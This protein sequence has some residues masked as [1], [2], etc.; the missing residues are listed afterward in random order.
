MTVDL[1]DYF[2]DLDFD[3]WPNYESRIMKTTTILLELFK[4]YKVTATFFT[5]GYI[6]EQFPELIERIVQEGHEVASH[7]YSHLD[8]RK[9]TKDQFE[10]D[11]VKSI[12]ILE[13]TAGEK[14]HGFRAPFFSINHET[15]WALDI[16]KKYLKYDSSI[17]PVRT[18]LYGISNAPRTIYHPSQK[19]P[20]RN[21]DEE[22]FLELPPAT[23]AI[24]IIGNI[25]I[26]GGFHLRF[27]PYNCIKSGIKKI[28]KNANPAVCYIHPKDLDPKMPRIPQYKWHYYYG[29]KGALRKFENLLRD[30]KFESV[31][32]A[33]PI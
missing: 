12:N 6:A 13:K 2:C 18:P 25:P 23:Y 28:N 19:N 7:S 11:L 10:S 22:N 30:F 24:P 20:L 8:I 31:R 4:K 3:L 26:A 17:F 21:D 29:L 14:I 1:E 27:W 9:I 33:V 16:I 5:L 15:F 32:E